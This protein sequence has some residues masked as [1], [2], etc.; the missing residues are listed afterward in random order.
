MDG[1]PQTGRSVVSVRC[2]NI[3][4]A[5][6]CTS[7]WGTPRSPFL[8]CLAIKYINS[9]FQMYGANLLIQSLDKYCSL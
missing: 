1:L 7:Q 8:Y 3:Y 2:Q 5:K 6:L 9:V 4:F